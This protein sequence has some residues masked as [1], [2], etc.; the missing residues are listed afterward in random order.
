MAETAASGS[1][2]WKGLGDALRFDGDFLFFFSFAK[3][4]EVKELKGKMGPFLRRVKC[5]SRSVHCNSPRQ[6]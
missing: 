3:E 6:G 4:T 5:K 1:G 2:E